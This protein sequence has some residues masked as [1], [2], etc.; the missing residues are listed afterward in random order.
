MAESNG[1]AKPEARVDPDTKA[2][3][4]N[5]DSS[6]ESD[7]LPKEKGIEVAVPP[8]EV[9]ESASPK[10]EAVEVV[11]ETEPGS[12][13]KSETE[14]KLQQL[15]PGGE[16][17]SAAVPTHAGE[18][19]ADREGADLEGTSRPQSP[20]DETDLEKVRKATDEKTAITARRPP[21]RH[22][23][24]VRPTST[25]SVSPEKSTHPLGKFDKP[26][27]PGFAPDGTPYVG[28]GT[29]EERTWKE[30]TRLRE[31]AFWARVGRAQ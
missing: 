27:E 31:D 29:W 6:P 3:A 14:E 26:E 7:G 10:V 15:Q 13:N 22:P 11:A 20:S 24:P 17:H 5:S 1:H 30:L 23:A 19:S 28:D 12:S 4:L 25:H 2:T 8:A 18:S 21:P 9:A 16:D